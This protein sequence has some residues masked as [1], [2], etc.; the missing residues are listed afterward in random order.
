MNVLRTTLR[1]VLLLLAGLVVG[2]RDL[3][4]SAA[5]AQTNEKPALCDLKSLPENARKRLTE[6]FSS[7]KIQES[8]NLSKQARERWK[9]E[10]PLACPGIAIGQFQGNMSLGAN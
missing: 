7:W 5:L 6:E 8:R 10:K 3:S 9:S 4:T 1:L 2:Q